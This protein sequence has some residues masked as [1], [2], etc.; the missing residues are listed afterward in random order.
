M[1]RK[2]LKSFGSKS[3]TGIIILKFIRT[4]YTNDRRKLRKIC[5]QVQDNW[6]GL[7]FQK[8]SHTL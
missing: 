1:K 2:N 3:G 8:T 4:P 5:M 6:R 7:G